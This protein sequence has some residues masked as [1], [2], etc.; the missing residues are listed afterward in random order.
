ME[1]QA[2]QVMV[3]GGGTAGWLTACLIAA[4]HRC[5]TNDAVKVTL[6]ESPDV[7]T[8]GVGEGTWP[9]MRVTLKR[10][11]LSETDLVKHCDASF[12]QGSFFKNWIG[13][14]TN[15]QYYHPFSLPKGHPEIDM[16][17]HWQPFDKQVSFCNA[18]SPQSR[19]CDQGLAPKSISTP[20]FAFSL[21]YGYHLDAGKFAELLQTHGTENLGVVH[22]K[23]HIEGIETH[24][25]GSIAAVIGKQS[26][27]LEGNL[28]VDCTGFKS[29]LLGEHYQ[30]PFIEKKSVLFNDTALATQV[31]YLAEDDN[32]A[33]A[34]ISTA[35]KAGWIWDIG[36]PTRR[37]VGLVYSSEHW[38]EADAHNCL[39]HYASETLGLKAAEQLTIRKIEINPGHRE[40]FWHKNCVAVGLSAGFLEPLEASALALIEV[41]AKLISDQLMQS[42]NLM[43][44]VAK[45]FN[46]TMQ[47]HWARII[48]FLKLHYILS[49]RS[50]SQYW[51]DNKS[52]SSIPESLQESLQLWQYEGPSVFDA[53]LVQEL[54]PAAS[55]QYVWYGM[56]AHSNMSQTSKRFEEQGRARETFKNVA[57]STH[58]LIKALPKN[59]ELIGKIKKFGL[60]KI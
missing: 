7:K 44:I 18:V 1:K 35:Q 50:D 28:F 15:D 26:G 4:D 57:D 3:V 9:S 21:N 19:I 30:I 54:F 11:G 36:L 16:A 46:D 41:S 8:I 20:E 10:I 12:K 25:D 59:R 43:D 34:T 48:D 13:I 58:S 22:V 39:V 51:L 17:Y 32:I 37:G 47:Y 40:T 23:D 38:N 6:V 29:L 5:K 55:Y 2:L 45:R 27:K 52:D 60:Q 14:P 31:P 24:P 42:A 33:S 49:K 56:L 53:P